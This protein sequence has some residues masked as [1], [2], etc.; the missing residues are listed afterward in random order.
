MKLRGARAVHFLNKFP[1]NCL[2]NKAWL[3]AYHLEPQ[4][5]RVLGLGCFFGDSGVCAFGFTGSGFGFRVKIVL[6]GRVSSDTWN[7]DAWTLQPCSLLL[8][9]LTSHVPCGNS[10]MEPQAEGFTRTCR[11]KRSADCERYV[12]AWQARCPSP[13]VC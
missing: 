8:W 11:P 9:E 10:N 1:T 13:G 3:G 6:R 7:V 5:L 4:G 12:R 2:Q